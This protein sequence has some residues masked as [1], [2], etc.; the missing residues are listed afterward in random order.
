MKIFSLL[1]DL[2]LGCCLMCFDHLQV[3]E[4]DGIALILDHTLVDANNPCILKW[5]PR[6][7]SSSGF[8]SHL[9]PGESFRTF[10]DKW[11]GFLWPDAQPAALN[12]SRKLISLMQ[13]N[14]F[15][16]L[17]SLSVTGLVK[18]VM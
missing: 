17:F 6:F 9:V 1:A 3:R 15:V 5:E 8:L 2:H 14:S 4:L 12:R 10:G 18:E 13:P 11:H 16:L 7:V